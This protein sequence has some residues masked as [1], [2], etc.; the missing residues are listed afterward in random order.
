MGLREISV[1]GNMCDCVF[2]DRD[3]E[4]MEGVKC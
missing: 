2:D 1:I 4:S 3:L